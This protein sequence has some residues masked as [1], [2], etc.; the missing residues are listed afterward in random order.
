MPQGVE[1]FSVFQLTSVISVAEF[2]C[3]S[4]ANLPTDTLAAVLAVA[5][6]V[7]ADTAFLAMPLMVLLTDGKSLPVRVADAIYN[8]P[9]INPR[10]CRGTHKA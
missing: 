8:F 4:L 9:S 3:S 7:G 5:L 2:F 6:R 10:L 1:V